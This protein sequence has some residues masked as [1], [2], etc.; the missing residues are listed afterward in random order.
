MCVCVRVCV[1]VCYVCVWAR[2]C[3]MQKPGKITCAPGALACHDIT[4]RDVQLN[5]TSSTHTYDCENVFGTE[6]D[7]SPPSCFAT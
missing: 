2:V 6:Q 5:V 7:C 3:A 1:Y 4:L